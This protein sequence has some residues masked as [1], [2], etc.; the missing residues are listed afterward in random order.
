MI[1]VFRVRSLIII[2]VSIK[3]A[4]PNLYSDYR[5]TQIQDANMITLEQI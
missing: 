3:L 1:L 4:A 5:V 2:I